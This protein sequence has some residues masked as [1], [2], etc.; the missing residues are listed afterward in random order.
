[1]LFKAEFSEFATEFVA[2][3]PSFHKHYLLT[4][5]SSYALIVQP[6]SLLVQSVSQLLL[7]WLVILLKPLSFSL[8][9][10]DLSPEG[11]SSFQFEQ[12]ALM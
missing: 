1:M 4:V 11:L 10:L 8:S 5:I 2:Q 6:L 7:L 3:T 9:C 12:H